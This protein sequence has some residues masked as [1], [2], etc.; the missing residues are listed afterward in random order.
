MTS[1]FSFSYFSFSLHRLLLPRASDAMTPDWQQSNDQGFFD[2]LGPMSKRIP[3]WYQGDRDNQNIGLAL[4]WLGLDTAECDHLNSFCYLIKTS[5]TRNALPPLCSLST[6]WAPWDDDLSELTQFHIVVFDWN[7]YQDI[8][9]TIADD[10]I[11]MIDDGAI[12]EV[13]RLQ[14]FVT[15][16]FFETADLVDTIG[17][18]RRSYMQLRAEHGELLQR[19]EANREYT[20]RIMEWIASRDPSMAGPFHL[21]LRPEDLAPEH[22]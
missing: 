4:P 5:H 12:A 7:A 9:R 2:D 20:A 21:L 18:L 19:F 16:H 15:V 3:I 6:F 13:H 14:T 11:N 22:T 1:N 8:L 10:A 17:G